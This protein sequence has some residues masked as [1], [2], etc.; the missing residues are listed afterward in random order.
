MFNHLEHAIKES[1]GSHKQRLENK[2]KKNEE[3]RK[4]YKLPPDTSVFQSVLE[5]MS[6]HKQRNG[7][8]Y[9]KYGKKSQL[10]SS[11][12]VNRTQVIE[13]PKQAYTSDN[14][15]QNIASVNN[16]NSLN[17]SNITV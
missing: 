1:L 14:R 3:L 16:D 7:S 10:S 9:D 8:S 6:E 15:K 13:D 12:A 17:T 4:N 5:N 11:K 2:K